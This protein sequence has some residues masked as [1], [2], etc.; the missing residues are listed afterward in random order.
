MGEDKL[1]S[2]EFVVPESIQEEISNKLAQ[3]VRDSYFWNVTKA[4]SEKVMVALT[5]DGFTERVSTAVV[6]K[7][8]ISEDDYV[9]GVTDSVKDALL[10]T[11]KVLSEE[12]L[13]K[14]EDKIKSYGFIN[15]GR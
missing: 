15:I 14:V 9:N 7:I 6:E 13:K 5:E 11:T 8:K 2:V 4:V 1:V 12:V 10:N 3:T